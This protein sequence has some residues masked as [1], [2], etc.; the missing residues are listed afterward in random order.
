[1]PL[2]LDEEWRKR[3]FVPGWDRATR[4][5]LFFRSSGNKEIGVE[6]FGGESSGSFLCVLRDTGNTAIE[7]YAATEWIE[8]LGRVLYAR[9]E[10]SMSGAVI[11]EA[12]GHRG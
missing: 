4:L 8:C 6:C 11:V 1:M 5:S 2:R 7:E 12:K 10:A 3:A 9:L